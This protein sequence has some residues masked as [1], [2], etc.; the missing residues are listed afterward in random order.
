MSFG[1]VRS[2]RRALSRIA[3]PAADLNGRCAEKFPGTRACIRCDECTDESG[4][5]VGEFTCSG[6]PVNVYCCAE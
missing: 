1:P 2:T 4:Q 6:E 5:F 3:A